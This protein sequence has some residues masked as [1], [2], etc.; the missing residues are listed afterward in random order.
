MDMSVKDIQMANECMKRYSTPFATEWE[1]TITT[2]QHRYTTMRMAK[3]LKI[4][5]TLNAEEDDVNLDIY[6]YWWECKL[7]QLL[8]KLH[9]QILLNLNK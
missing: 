5:K 4:V 6:L 2:R 9:W 8:Q 1:Y 3:I 7:V